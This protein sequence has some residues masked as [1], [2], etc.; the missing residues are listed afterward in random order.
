MDTKA[1]I[2]EAKAKFSH[3]LAKRYLKDKYQSKL[4]IAEQGGLWKLSPEFIAM[5][6][7][8]PGPKVIL[9][10]TYGNPVEIDREEFL[11]KATK[12]YNFVMEEY[13]SEWKNLKVN[14]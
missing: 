9:M 10:D 6:N 7:S 8:Y 3:N 5:L 13:L 2:K 12:T 4:L 14:R 1:I 11:E